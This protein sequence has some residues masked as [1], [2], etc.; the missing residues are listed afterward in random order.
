MV[1]AAEA[2]GLLQNIRRASSSTVGWASETVRDTAKASVTYLLSDKHA[3]IPMSSGVD[4][5]GRLTLQL[6]GA[7]QLPS[8]G[9]TGRVGDA[10]GVVTVG[11]MARRTEAK[12][13]SNPQWEAKMTFPVFLPDGDEV[14][15]AHVEVFDKGNLLASALLR[16]EAPSG[17]EH[18]VAHRL[19]TLDLTTPNRLE[20]GFLRYTAVVTS[21]DRLES[22]FAAVQSLARMPL[23]PTVIESASH[24]HREG[25][26]LTEQAFDLK[27]RAVATLRPSSFFRTARDS[28]LATTLFVGRTAKD[29]TSSLLKRTITTVAS[30]L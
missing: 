26:G 27:R 29:A 9:I 13:E 8:V 28:S 17:G 11:G 4:R 16:I 15:Q 20:G 30:L 2:P 5:V 23:L 3:Q 18:E 1:A 14:L 12:R 22:R 21:L 6:H 7:F 24:L 10:Y 25:R 19:R